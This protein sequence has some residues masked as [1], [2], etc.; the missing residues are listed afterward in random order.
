MPICP[1]IA[2]VAVRASETAVRRALA[3]MH[4]GYKVDSGL[5]WRRDSARYGQIVLRSSYH[6]Q[7]GWR[8]SSIGAAKRQYIGAE[9]SVRLACGCVS[10]HLH[11]RAPILPRHSQP[12]LLE[13][14]HRLHR[15]HSGIAIE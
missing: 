7:I 8:S 6:L 12:G 1:R 4:C 10:A 3:P 14:G 11:H 9:R 13:T 5:S 15:F 2:D